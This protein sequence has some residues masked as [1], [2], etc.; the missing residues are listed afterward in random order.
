MIGKIERGS[1]H[2]SSTVVRLGKENRSRRR[3]FCTS[4]ASWT[5]PASQ[6]GVAEAPFIDFEPL[7]LCSLANSSGHCMTVRRWFDDNSWRQRVNSLD[8]PLLFEASAQC[9]TVTII[10]DSKV[11]LTAKKLSGCGPLSIRNRG[12]IQIPFQGLSFAEFAKWRIC[13]NSWA[14]GANRRC[15][16]QS[17]G[18]KDRKEFI[19][20]F[21][22][23]STYNSARRGVGTT[24]Y[25]IRIY[26]V[27]LLMVILKEQW[28]ASVFAAPN[29]Y[30]HLGLEAW[31]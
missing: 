4:Q 24:S 29:S 8:L 23:Q 7:H 14:D 25:R 11:K 22:P 5:G 13:A 28:W 12:W 6:N 26:E 10:I 27:N 21:H 30:F 17:T 15:Q 9:V 3:S 1:F 31:C 16:V 19:I 20:I 18:L 2:I